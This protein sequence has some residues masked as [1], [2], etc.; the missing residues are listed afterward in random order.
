MPD[1]QEAR[2]TPADEIRFVLEAKAAPLVARNANGL[3]ALIHPDFLYVN[4]SGRVFDKAGYI[5][6]FCASGRIVFTEQRFS[7]LDI[8]LIDNFAIATLG[9]EDELKIGVRMV[10]GRYTS[11]CVFSRSSAR[12]QWAA[13]QTMTVGAA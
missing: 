6:A 10:S 2:L 1:V 9:I 3:A 11:L 8:K 5:D 12:W 7:D 4:A 13:G